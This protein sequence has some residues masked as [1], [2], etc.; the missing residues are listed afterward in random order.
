MSI[1]NWPAGRTYGRYTCELPWYLMLWRILWVL[2][3]GFA[4]GLLISVAVIHYAPYIQEALAFAT[5]SYRGK[6]RG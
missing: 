3:L 2:P 1:L 4:Y 5:G 6:L